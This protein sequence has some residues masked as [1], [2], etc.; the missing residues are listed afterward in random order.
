MLNDLRY[1][2]R[3][4]RKSPGFT[5]A[6]VLT[7]ALG[8]GATTAI[9]SVVYAV[10]LRPLPYREPERLVQ[11]YETGLRGGGSRDWVSFPNFLDW[12]QQNQVFE[13]V[14]A[15]RY[16]PSTV[17]GDGTPETVLGLQVTSGL[18]G[19]LGVH[20]SL[21][22]TFVPEEDQPGKGNVAILSYN[23]WQRRFG[24]S[25]AIVGQPITI[26]GQ[27]CTIVGVMPDAFQFPHVVP[28]EV[29]LDGINLWIPMRNRD[30]QNR[31][32]RNYWAVAR[33]KRGV[34]LAQ[35]QRNMDGIGAAIAQ[36][37]PND[38]RDLGVKVTSLQ[39]HLTREVN[40][41][42]WLL[43][44]AIG[45]VL[46][47][48][49]ANL[50]SLLLSKVN[51]RLREMAVRAALGASRFRL[52]RQSL[53]EAWLLSLA[54]A[55]VGLL[56]AVWAIE[57]FRRLGPANIPRLQDAELDLRVLLFALVLSLGT[58]LLFGLVPSL[59]ASRTNLNDALKDASSRNTADRSRGRLRDSLIVGEVAMAL[60]LLTGAG[61]LIQSFRRLLSVDLGFDSRDVVAGWIL[62]PP[63]R[64]P[65]PEQQAAFFQRLVER[66]QALPGVAAAAV[67]N[68]VPLS[69]LNDQGGFRIEGRADPPPGAE[70]LRANRPKVSAD[71]FQV[72]GIRLLR[73]RGFTENDK[74]GSVEVAI[75]SDVAA[76]KYWPNQDPLG[77]RISINRRDGKPVW[78]EIVGIVKGVTHFG[79]ETER[80][81]EIYV[82]HLQVPSF[83]SAL[84]VRTRGN[85]M[86][87]AGNI[88]KEVA[89]Q[90]PTLA[91]FNMHSMH[92]L[93]SVA[94]S[95]RRFQAALLGA[96]AG[97]ALVL[98]AVG[99]YGVVA[100]WM[101][102]RVREIAIR[103]A[104][105]ARQVDVLW[106]TL[107]HGLVLTAAGLVLGLAG[108]SAMGRF[109]GSLL[110]R[111]SAVDLRIY[112]V[113]C[114]ILAGV[115]LLACYFPAR[116]AA[117]VDPMVA[118][119]CE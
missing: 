35:A 90:D 23:L 69:G 15:Y 67:C 50:A 61:L 56:F 8:I 29:A 45:L 65:Q 31:S 47:I 11:L 49:C 28:G 119:R 5:A 63:D 41:P 55:A 44:G 53:T 105:G 106:L 93:V 32:S 87:M 110:F 73:G 48:A 77:E 2:I 17:A 89:S 12:C 91:L 52:A 24:G 42:L 39:H 57:S 112:A 64:Y 30:V 118:L 37:Y 80:Y 62:L 43:L 6:A 18:F 38:N 16:W 81:A 14:A 20:P 60:V 34:T 83:V 25:Q 3:Q 4:F 88:K 27:S 66:V 26:D 22:R 54:G 40:Q 70:P 111:T 85:P 7:L 9:F 19:V 68:S 72:M 107:R 58:V 46:L 97:L 104:V 99:I 36:Q 74:A 1:A 10:L 75:I 79:L 109:I 94:Q 116:R 108:A 51:T 59:L 21:G 102:Q 115:A 117:K 78:R 100:Y 86:A 33:L 92:E 13:E 95:R 103:M 82:P 84:V 96:F 76:Q 98:A 113:V 114:L 101:S 71:Y